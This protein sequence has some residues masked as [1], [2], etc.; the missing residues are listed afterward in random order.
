MYAYAYD[1]LGNLLSVT[2]QS[3]PTISY[4]VDGMNRRIAKRSTTGS[5]TTVVR[6]S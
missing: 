1:A 2:P 5:T 3:G 4:V 6:G